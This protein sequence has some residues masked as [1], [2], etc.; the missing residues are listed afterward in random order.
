MKVKRAVLYNTKQVALL[1]DWSPDAIYRGA[2]TG[3]LPVMPIKVGSS[4]R[5]PRAA[6]NATVGLPDD[7]DPFEYDSSDDPETA[8]A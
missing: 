2:R 1:W 3:R 8:G 6:V 4:L 5:W 7:A